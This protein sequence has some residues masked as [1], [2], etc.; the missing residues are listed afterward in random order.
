MIG[1]SLGGLVALEGLAG[2][3]GAF[4]RGLGPAA[5]DKV[6]T[7][8]SPVNGVYHGSPLS[9]LGDM[10]GSLSYIRPCS[11]QLFGVPRIVRDHQ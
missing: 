7:M 5:I 3:G 8:D 10:V 1:H 6:I 2:V 4:V 9:L 11:Q